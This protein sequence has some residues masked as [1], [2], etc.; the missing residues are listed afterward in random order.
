MSGRI[1]V[2][3]DRDRCTGIG[4]CESIAPLVFSVGDDGVLTI[5][6]DAAGADRDG[7]I[8]AVDSCP[9]RSL[10]IVQP[11]AGDGAQSSEVAT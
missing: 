5:D 7:V 10:S 4:I 6:A 9:A 3:V 8:A 11:T 2:A 1:Q